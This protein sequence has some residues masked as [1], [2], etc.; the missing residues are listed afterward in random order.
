MLADLDLGQLLRQIDPLTISEVPDR[1]RR[2]PDLDLLPSGQ[3]VKAILLRLG[4][5]DGGEALEAKVPVDAPDGASNDGQLRLARR[6]VRVLADCIVG[7]VSVSCY[8]GFGHE[9]SLLNVS[10]IAHSYKI[11]Q[12][13]E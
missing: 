3:E 2:V 6:L 12:F 11:A 13:R 7:S 4:Q 5:R 1:L 9:A 8:G 10:P